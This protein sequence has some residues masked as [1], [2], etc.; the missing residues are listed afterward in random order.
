MNKFSKNQILL[1]VAVLAIGLVL[2]YW[3]NSGGRD[4][5]EVM[6]EHT[7]GANETYTCS[8][9]P[10]IR[11]EGP[12][13][14]PI[15][16]M[17]LT[18]AASS[19]DGAEANPYVLKMT[20]EAM[21]LANIQTFKVESG[22]FDNALNL[23]GKIRV[24]EEKRASLTARFPGR[25]DRLY[26]NY[27][28]QRIAQGD[29]I[30][31]V[32]SPE[33]IAAQREL[34]EASKRKER[35][36]GLYEAARE[37]LKLWRLRESQIE[38]IEQSGTVQNAFDIYSDISGVVTQRMASLGDYV[39]TGAVLAEVADLSTVWVVLDAFEANLSRISKGDTFTFTVQGLGSKEYAATVNDITPYLD[40]ATRAVEIRAVVDNS[41]G[42]LSPEMFVNAQL[43]LGSGDGEATALMVPK[44]AVLWTGTNSVVYIKVPG[45]S[46]PAF[47][48]REV[49][50]GGSSGNQYAIV[51]GID[52]GDEIVSNGVFAVDGAAQLTGNYSMMNKAA[53]ALTINPDFLVQW[54]ATL[55]AYFEL[56]NQLVASEASAS[57]KAAGSMQQQLEGTDMA[58]LSEAAHDQWMAALPDI[59]SSLQNIRET[60]EIEE[61]R[62]DFL[63]LSNALIDILQSFGSGSIT[64]YQS[65]C[66]MANNDEGA[67]WLS[68]VEEILNPYYGDA[69]LSCGEVRK[70][71]R[72]DDNK[73]QQP[74]SNQPQ[75]HQHH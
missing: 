64:L 47:E 3:M 19:G 37:K 15:C 4:G 11:Q 58:L 31:S 51:S 67:Y 21:A 43:K 30:A 48:M 49:A 53:A 27:T 26:V 12:G 13:K 38:Q 2:G 62:A 74:S 5:D 40:E 24:N 55:E 6:E 29:R 61:Q 72:A 22:N 52:A 28:G 8:M 71:Y 17:D 41:D 60:Q 25:I 42:R 66:P 65:Y 69:M 57:Q 46:R 18:P 39:S 50:L 56:K 44:S 35:N 45:Q 70:T 16:G 1:L 14:C 34:L 36:P 73:K 54:E 68:E 23:T 20:E 32:Y 7:H 63:H 10:Q 33:L 9:H 75:G 59:R